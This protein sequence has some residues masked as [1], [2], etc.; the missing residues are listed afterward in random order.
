LKIIQLCARLEFG[1]AVSHHV[2]EIG[3][4]L[5]SL[6][7]QTKIFANTLDEFGKEF[8][9]TDDEFEPVKDKSDLLIY[10]YSIYCENYRKYLEFGA[11]KI[12][13]YHNITPPE[14]FEAHDAGVAEFLRK[15]R[16]L[17][18]SLS[19]CDLALGDSEF[20]RTELLNY[21]FEEERTGVLPIFVDYDDLLKQKPVERIRREFGDSFKIIFVGRKVPNKR[22]E[23]LI[24]TF[25]Y[26]KRC[27]NSNSRLLIV[28]P[29][30]IE[31]Y[32]A[33]LRWLIDS[34]G[35]FDDVVMTGKVTKQELSTYYSI[36]DVYLSMSEHEGFAVPFIEA[37]AFGVPVIAYS[38]SAIPYT[39]AGSGVTFNIKDFA[40][41][42]E[43]IEIIRTDEN[44]KSK[45]VA[46][47]KERL[48]AF[49]KE[50]VQSALDSAIEKAMN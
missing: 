9:L 35:L 12:L 28:G 20:N 24:R 39:L 6:G 21:G 46:S 23:D 16:E 14:F 27:I 25:F 34:F 36:A 19:S 31:K 43:L 7:H 45:L 10:H 42:A 44:L 15:G 17:L 50:S 48:K 47:G 32:D 22:I 49:S 38:C 29:Q 26:Y 33:Q 13:I 8:A 18:P 5:S 2:I 4:Y 37:M 11:K 3:K 40:R 1:D 41:V 30:W